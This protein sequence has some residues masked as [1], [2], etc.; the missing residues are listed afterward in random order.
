MADDNKPIK[1]ARYAIGEIILVVIGILIAL[2]INTWNQNR[3]RAAEEL[4]ILKA[5]KIGLEKDLKDLEL[6]A[7]SIDR[8]ISSGQKIIDALENDLPY[9]DS[10]AD[11]FGHLMFPVMFLHSTSAFETL[12]SKGID[13]ISNADLRD[14]IIG[15][16]DS[17][18][19]FF[20]KNE[21]IT[22]DEAERGLKHIFPTRFHES[23]VYDLNKDNYEPRLTPIDYEALKGDQEFKYF[24]KTYKNRLNVLLNFHYNLRLI[25]SVQELL[26]SL[27]QEIEVMEE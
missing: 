15:V 16:Y 1:Y 11:H 23:Y 13:L 22:L 20:L 7:E 14:Q 10:I 4:H 6:N 21:A 24:L 2:Q 3:I 5:L 9:Q 25:I 8:S 27:G 26:D 19:T 18:Y 17:G 12:K